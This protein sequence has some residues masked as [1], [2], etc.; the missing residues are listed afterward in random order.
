MSRP[1][2]AVMTMVR[3]EKVM[4][5]RWLA[6]YGTLVG[7]SNLIVVDDATT[8]GSTTGLDVTVL[9]LPPSS[10]ETAHFDAQRAGMVSALGTALLHY[11]DVVIYVDADEFLVID[12][13]VYESFGDFLTSTEQ[14]AFVAPLGVN[15]VHVES[16]EAPFIPQQPI[17]EQRRYVKFVPAMCKPVVRRQAR[18]R[19]T[20]G[21]HGASERY[22]VDTGIL[23]V[24]TKFMD[25]DLA[26]RSQRVRHERWQQGMGQTSSWRMPVGRFRQS[27]RDWS[28]APPDNAIDT[29]EPARIDTSQVVTS[30]RRHLLGPRVY[31]SAGGQ[32]AAMRDM[33]L[34]ALPNR[35]AP[36]LYA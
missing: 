36:H 23:L 5:P 19:W 6:H 8:D 31:R 2:V 4:L 30:T 33:P 29:L 11:A 9:R 13:D 35:F 24:H 18:A 25:S 20:P 27:Y 15:L 7:R 22:A 34:L 21:F 3:N 1:T 12:P 10:G 17:L 32:I 28:A 16:L 26:A 14:A